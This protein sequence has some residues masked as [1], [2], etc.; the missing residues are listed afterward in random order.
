M[1][2]SRM[3]VWPVLWWNNDCVVIIWQ[4]LAVIGCGCIWSEEFH[5]FIPKPNPIAVLLFI[6]NNL[7]DVKTMLTCTP[8]DV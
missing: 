6:Q 8:I 7:H 1:R 4:Y 2:D 3:Q 5:K